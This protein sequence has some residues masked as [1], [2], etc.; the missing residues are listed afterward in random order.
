MCLELLVGLSCF[1][2]I[3]HHFYFLALRFDQVSL[4]FLAKEA[5]M[6][7]Q[8]LVVLFNVMPGSMLQHE[9]IC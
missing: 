5:G 2:R 1:L 3:V 6:L 7:F 4:G 8:H 9:R